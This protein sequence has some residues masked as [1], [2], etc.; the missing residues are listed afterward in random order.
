[1]EKS[2]TIS[3]FKSGTESYNEA[4]DFLDT[5]LSF[6]KSV[7]TIKQLFAELLNTIPNVQIYTLG[8]VVASF[9]Q[10][11]TVDSP[12]KRTKKRKTSK[13]HPPSILINKEF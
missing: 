13:P 2:L 10:K 5:F 7:E 1:M 9:C 6:E 8:I 4:Q 3:I 12:F 11:D